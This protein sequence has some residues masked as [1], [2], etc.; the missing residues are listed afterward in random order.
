MMIIKKGSKKENILKSILK[1]RFFLF[2]LVKRNL[3]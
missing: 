2:Q 3:L 1:F